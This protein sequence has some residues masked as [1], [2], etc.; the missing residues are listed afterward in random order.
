MKKRWLWWILLCV[1]AALSM[2]FWNWGKERPIILALPFWV[3]Y[4]MVLVLIYALSFAL[5]TMYEW[6][7]G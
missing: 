1:L 4:V 6:R 5:F 7:E 3:W 2:D